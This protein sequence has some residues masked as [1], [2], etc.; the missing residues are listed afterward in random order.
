MGR[1]VSMV[2]LLASMAAPAWAGTGNSGSGPHAA[3]PS[4]TALRAYVASYASGAYAATPSF[5]RQ[6]GLACSA[7]H[8]HYPELTAMG[9][10]FKLNGYVFRRGGADS[11]SAQSAS[12]DQNLLINLV[13]PLSFMLQTSY[14]VLKR[15][16]PGTQNGVAFFP[17]QLSL[18]TGGEITPHVGGFLQVTFDPQSGQLGIDNADFRYATHLSLLGQHSTFGISLNNNPTV[19]DVWNSTPAWGF[20]YGSS[21]AAP[22]PSAATMID[23]TLGGQ[24]AG[25]TAYT[26]WGSHLYL[27][28]GAYRAAPLGVPRP[29]DGTATDVLAGAAPYWRVAIPN[30]I[31]GKYLSVGAYGMSSRIYPAGVTGP[32]NRFTDVAA[33]LSFLWPMGNNSFT[34]EATYIHESQH[35]N[36]GGSANATNTL[37]T[38]R[39]DMMYHVGHMYAFTAAPFFTSG[40]T[41]TLLYAAAPMTGSR[42]GSPNSS[43]LIGEVD[44]MPWQNL[45]FQFQYVAYSKF[46]GAST[47]YDGS[48][49]NAAD[50]NTL[51]FLTWV[52]F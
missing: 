41:D 25:L 48:G 29:L 50:N 16:Q 49:R 8:T 52:L 47:N 5:A 45:R 6:T 40:S 4:E 9:R 39:F 10:A 15:A 1:T 11:I 20:P 17:D 38:F 30:T 34:T 26:M 24:V 21:A 35:W 32:T 33:D 43:G 44:V 37:K 36:A 51:Y 3:P 27:E 28:G 19:Q 42:I 46:N 23:G 14:T 18:F 2:V 31:S 7:C 13:T 22:A 12:G